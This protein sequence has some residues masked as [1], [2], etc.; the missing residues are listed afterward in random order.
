MRFQ[1]LIQIAKGLPRHDD[2]RAYDQIL[3]DLERARWH[4]WHGCWHRCLDRLRWLTDDLELFTFTSNTVHKKLEKKLAEAIT[5]F[6]RN[7]RYMVNQ[8]ISKRFC[9]KQ[10]MS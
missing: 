7:R 2:Q 8:V 4:L 9:K 3:R 10:Q 6:S 1:N 5:Y